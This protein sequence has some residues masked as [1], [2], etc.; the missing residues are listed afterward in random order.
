MDMFIDGKWMP[1]LGG[2]RQDVVNPATGALIDTVPAPAAQTM[3]IIAIR[4]AERAFRS[5]QHDTRRDARE[6]AEARRAIDA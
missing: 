3:R 4:A 5:W 2:A 1:A 6:T